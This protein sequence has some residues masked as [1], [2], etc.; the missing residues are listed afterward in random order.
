PVSARA[1]ALDIHHHTLRRF[2]E[3]CLVEIP[4]AIE[5][6]VPRPAE[7]PIV[8]A[9]SQQIVLSALPEEIVACVSSQEEIAPA[10]SPNVV[11][12]AR[13]TNHVVTAAAIG[14]IPSVAEHDDVSA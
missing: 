4:A 13:G 3:V 5:N 1:L 6:V 12:P 8:P 14:T 7:K 2:A 11:W 10:A 9:V